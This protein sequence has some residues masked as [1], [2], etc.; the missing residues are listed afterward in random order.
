MRNSSD[1]QAPQEQGTVPDLERASS[2]VRASSGPV[3][4]EEDAAESVVANNTL[5]QAV[6]ISEKEDPS[7]P[8]NEVIT[9]R[10]VDDGGMNPQPQAPSR[11]ELP[12]A[13][14]QQQPD[15]TQNYASNHTGEE[16]SNG[17]N[18]K[19]VPSMDVRTANTMEAGLADSSNGNA[20]TADMLT[21]AT[22][23]PKGMRL[24]MPSKD[25]GT[26]LGILLCCI[27]TVIG[28]IV[29]LA[30]GL[31][32]D[33]EQPRDAFLLTNGATDPPT[34][35]PLPD[36][37]APTSMPSS[38]PTPQQTPAST[39]KPTEPPSAEPKYCLQ[40]SDACGD[41]TDL[42]GLGADWQS[43]SCTADSSTL[44]CTIVACNEVFP[45]ITPNRVLMLVSPTTNNKIELDSDI[46]ELR[47][48]DKLVYTGFP[49]IK[50]DKEVDI[51]LPIAYFPN[52]LDIQ[53]WLESS[54]F[55]FFDPVDRLPDQ[56]TLS[57]AQC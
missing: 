11:S 44:K 57:F 30:V 55:G 20:N 14:A 43:L 36:T 40:G 12:S 27:V 29:A 35:A 13:V 45:L 38:L 15:E 18:A 16:D 33:D 25:K 2:S 21:S 39:S 49:S 46:F 24:V 3:F 17:L 42:F 8:G 23:N 37:P 4:S 56:I 22:R 28:I 41:G 50:S 34:M 48:D 52:L 19:M 10:Q 1:E 31:S 47:E 6:V 32:G 54:I 9:A 53:V 7:S 5:V 26:I 51:E